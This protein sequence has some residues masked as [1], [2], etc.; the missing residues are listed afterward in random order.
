MTVADADAPHG[1]WIGPPPSLVERSAAMFL[2]VTG[3]M[4]AGVG[5]L[6]LGGLQAEGRLSA[7][8]I[9]Q[10]GTVELL[11]MG[12]GAA[13]AGA[14]F[15]VQRLRP[16]AIGCGLAMALLNWLTL[17]ADG[18]MITLIR[19]IN[20]LPSGVL[21]WLITGM[22]VRAPRAGQWSGLY[23]T[24]QTLAQFVVVAALTAFVIGSLGTKGG[25]LCLSGLG[26]LA[27]LAG[28]VT[29]PAYAPLTDAGDATRAG[30]PSG[31]GWLALL[32]AFCFQAFILA[33]WIYVEPLS[34]QSGHAEGTAGIALSASLAAQVL[35]GATATVLAGRAAWFR[36]LAGSI[37]A[38]IVLLG[39]FA[40]LP[41]VA[42]F[43]AAS[44]AFG[45]LWMFASPWLT[46]MAIEADP[47]R[48]AA[49][50]GPGA[51]LLGCSAGPFLASLVVTD[52]DVRA[53]LALGAGLAAVA[54]AIVAGL[55][56]TRPRGGD[57]R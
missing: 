53:C 8:Q 19:G 38:M 51:A 45:F 41:G 34:R 29:P 32:A 55:H 48:N 23:L 46:P 3:V 2:G 25:F 5:P 4:F 39:L 14:L 47:S 27:A 10:A 20:G 26:V 28:F 43:L 36:A 24:I 42:V 6:L 18:N 11:A 7:A 1:D 50:L 9:G 57:P 16:V 22:I 33:V 15:G 40:L 56:F 12:I 54:L 30:W 52:S 31:R 35:G 37:A 21:I 49:L 17:R 44:A 13:L